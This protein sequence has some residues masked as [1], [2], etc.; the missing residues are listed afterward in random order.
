MIPY[1]A[2]GIGIAVLLGVWA[3]LI[4]ETAKERLIIIGVPLLV[5]LIPVVFRSRTGSL[6]SLLGF[7]IYGLG[8]LI[9]LRFNGVGIR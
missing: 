2:I 6:I 8:C 1:A 9:Y 7:M 3:F 4:A 5:F